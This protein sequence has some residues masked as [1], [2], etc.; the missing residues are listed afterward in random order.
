MMTTPISSL[1][2]NHRQSVATPGTSPAPA[3]TA[4]SE[5]TP[6]AIET[7]GKAEKP[8]DNKPN[9]PSNEALQNAVD[10]A[11]KALEANA[12]RDMRFSIDRDTGISV[13]KILDQHTG[14]TIRQIPSQEMLEIA[15]SID[16]QLK[17][18]IVRQYA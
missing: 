17:G 16:Q 9:P 12:S 2:G 15:K 18:R 8:V 3:R 13:V 7:T 14:A 1:S 6:P 10:Q 11:N 4:T 5:T